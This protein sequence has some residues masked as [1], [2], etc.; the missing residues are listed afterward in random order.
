M[1]QYDPHIFE[2]L[3]FTSNDIEHFWDNCPDEWFIAIA[4]KDNVLDDNEAR[5]AAVCAARQ[6][7]H[8][9]DSQVHRDAIDV[10]E[11]HSCDRAT[12]EELD[13]AYDAICSYNFE[14]IYDS[15]VNKVQGYA[16]DAAMATIYESPRQALDLAAHA[17]SRIS[18]DGNERKALVRWMRANMRP[19][20]KRAID[21]Y[22]SNR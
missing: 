16:R 3:L 8:L 1:K 15:L 18:E 2:V 5:F 12:Q 21:Y 20:W 6:V 13:D 4:T 7:E 11:R 9:L 19:K 10:A 17:L 22:L 14:H